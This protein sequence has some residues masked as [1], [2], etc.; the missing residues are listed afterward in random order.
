MNDD[1][2]VFIV[3]Y[4]RANNQLTYNYLKNNGYS[5][6]IYFV[7]SD[8]DPTIPEYQ[9]KFGLDKCLVFNK[10]ES[11]SLFDIGDN[12]D[13]E[14]AVVYARN[15]LYDLAA[16]VGIKWAL[17]LDDDYIN[18][19][20]CIGH[21]EQ[22]PTHRKIVRSMDKLIYCTLHY[23]KSIPA[24]SVAWAQTGD[25]IGGM[26]NTEIANGYRIKR[27]VM[28]SFFF[29]VDNPMQFCG[30]I[31]EDL[32]GSILA[33]MTGKLVFTL[34]YVALLQ[35]ATQSNT[36]GLTDIYLNMGTYVKSFYSVMMAPSCVKIA[37]MGDV[38]KR[39][40][41]QVSW[42]NAASKIISDKYRKTA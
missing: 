30:R 14:R 33:S 22:P 9:E 24:L 18:W 27:K 23:F 2:A 29:D 28:N 42:N 32:T 41:H 35:L 26:E 13:D 16:G 25:L 6:K 1:F 37:A 38:H 40:H 3:T 17:V 34:Y 8:D 7:L 12:F 11:L 4:K 31:N 20:Y 19:Q 5:G 15:K 36:G 39:I 10:Q 21:N